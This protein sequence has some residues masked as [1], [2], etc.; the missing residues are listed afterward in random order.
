LLCV[1]GSTN[2]VFVNDFKVKEHTLGHG[3]VVQFGG[4]A[5]IPVGTRFGG[6]G[7]H[8]R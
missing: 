7:S 6:T 4:A 1:Q 2:G 3:D 5:D 8:I